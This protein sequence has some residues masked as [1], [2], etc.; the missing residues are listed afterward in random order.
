MRRPLLSALV[1]DDHRIVEMYSADHRAN[2]NIMLR[3]VEVRMDRVYQALA[4]LDKGRRSAI[5]S[6]MPTAPVVGVQVF[7][8][9][10]ATFVERREKATEA[11]HL[12][13]ANVA[14]VVDH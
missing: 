9:I 10:D 5:A 13:F 4:V 7:A 11:L 12:V 6:L 1:D 14:S 3:C 2:F 8:D